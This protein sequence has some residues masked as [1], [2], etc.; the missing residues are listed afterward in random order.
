MRLE[1]EDWVGT[2]ANSILAAIV[3]ETTVKDLTGPF[4]LDDFLR[5]WLEYDPATVAVLPDPPGSS[6]S[7]LN[8]RRTYWFYEGCHALEEGGWIAEVGDGKFAVASLALLRA[9][10]LHADS[11]PPD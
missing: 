6:G 2:V 5:A 11:T 8:Q 10:M 3:K 7:T 9:Q 4:T 1:S